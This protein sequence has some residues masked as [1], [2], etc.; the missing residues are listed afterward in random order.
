MREAKA[1][2][3]CLRLAKQ[4][5]YERQGLD[6]NTTLTRT[7]EDEEEEEEEESDEESPDPGLSAALNV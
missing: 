4:E 5:E 3:S 6:P 2:R 1:K 7:T